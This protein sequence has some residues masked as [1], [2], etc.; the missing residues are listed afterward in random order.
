M[1]RV[2]LKYPL[3]GGEV[4]EIRTGPNPTVRMVDEQA[5][6]VC[7]WLEVDQVARDLT[8]PGFVSTLVGFVLAGTGWVDAVPECGTHVGSVSTSTGLVWHVYEVDAQWMR[9]AWR[10]RAHEAQRLLVRTEFGTELRAAVRARDRGLCRYCGSTLAIDLRWSAGAVS[11]E[12]LVYDVLDLSVPLSIDNVVL[13][14]GRC[15]ALKG[16]RPLH[17]SKLQLRPVPPAVAS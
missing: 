4:N 17:L 15:N 5:G 3:T 11:P 10:R 16:D 1:R 6:R 7:V 13:A 12:R 14:C 2:V 8:D 9:V